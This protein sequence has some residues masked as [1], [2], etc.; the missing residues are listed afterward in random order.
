MYVLD[1]TWGPQATAT[2]SMYHTYGYIQYT[3][4]STLQIIIPWE[5]FLEREDSHGDHDL[6]N[7]VELRFK[8]PPGVSYSYITIHLIGTT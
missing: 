5:F 4:Y 6:G 7:L 1:G 2:Y 8:A 3:T